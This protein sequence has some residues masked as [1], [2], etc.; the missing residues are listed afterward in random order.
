ML[1]TL[2]SIAAKV[3]KEHSASEEVV[4]TKWNLCEVY[5]P[6]LAKWKGKKITG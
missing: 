2:P 1:A 5:I 6:I 3:W 4:L